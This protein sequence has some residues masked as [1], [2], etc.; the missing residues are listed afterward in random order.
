MSIRVAEAGRHWIANAQ[1]NNLERTTIEHYQYLLDAHIAPFLGA[2]KLSRLTE[3]MVKEFRSKLIDGAAA[4]DGESGIKRSS[5]MVT[6]VVRALSMILADA[7][8]AG[9]VAQNVCRV[10]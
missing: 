7:M 9:S 1:E 10:A 3:P 8:E 4:P 6:R 5:S 2:V